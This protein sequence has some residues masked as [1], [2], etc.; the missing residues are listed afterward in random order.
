MVMR[1]TIDCFEEQKA[2]CRALATRAAN[3]TDREFWLRLACRWEE[4]L[5]AKQR[6]TLKVEVPTVRFERPIFK[7]RGRRAAA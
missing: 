2:Q 6:G 1:N 4:L 5:Q 3:K 7:K